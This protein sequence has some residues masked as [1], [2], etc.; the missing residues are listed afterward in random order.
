MSIHSSLRLRV[1]DSTAPGVADV[2]MN[3]DDVSLRCL[4]GASGVHVVLSDGE[5]VRLRAEIGAEPGEL[6]PLRVQLDEAGTPQ[7]RS[8]GRNV[9]L[10]PADARYDPPLP[11]RPAAAEVALDLAII[12][13]GTTRV[14]PDDATPSARLLDQKNAW[15][16]HV[17]KLVA[18]AAAL[19]RGGQARVSVL[20]FGDQSA[21]GVSASDLRPAYDLLPPPDEQLL[22][23]FSGDVLKQRLL[24]IRPTA[25]GDFVDA[26][27][28]AMEACTRLRWAPASRRLV[29]ISGDSPGCSL[30]HPLPKGADLCVRRHDVDTQA[31]QLHRQHV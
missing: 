26:L 14:W 28:D 16:E 20:A 25:G 21:P 7:L 24:S 17:E 8:D 6:V 12:V 30:L 1:W 3:D 13:D 4:A 19:A 27:A 22:Q 18:L 9:F 10:L 23:P 11:I 5:G 29:V 2:P 31:L 15:A